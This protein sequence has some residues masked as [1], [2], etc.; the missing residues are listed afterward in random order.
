MLSAHPVR[1]GLELARFREQ[2][3]S[4]RA[5]TIS[6][7][8]YVST[9]PY[10]SAD[11]KLPTFSGLVLTTAEIAL[12]DLTRMFSNNSFAGVKRNPSQWLA[13]THTT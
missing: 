4:S 5:F 1:L 3:Q 10:G 13:R 8:V 2:N 12:H 11:A 6:P 7:A 9:S